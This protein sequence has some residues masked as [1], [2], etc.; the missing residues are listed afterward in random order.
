MG[1]RA[2]GQ[3]TGDIL[4]WDGTKWVTLAAPSGGDFV[5]MSSGGA[6]H[7]QQVQE[8]ECPESGS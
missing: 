7:W 6:P 3:N 8:F 5:L 4:Y 1:G 2:S